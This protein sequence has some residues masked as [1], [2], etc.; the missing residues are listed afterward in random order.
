[1]QP[2][3]LQTPPLTLFFLRVADI[4]VSAAGR[5][6]VAG[7]WTGG[8]G[9]QPSS[10][11]SLPGGAVCWRARRWSWRTKAAGPMELLGNQHLQHRSQPSVSCVFHTIPILPDTHPP[12]LSMCSRSARRRWASSGSMARATA[13]VCESRSRKWKLAN[14]PSTSAAFAARC[15]RAFA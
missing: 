1:M 10:P 9:D 4:M 11:A 5:V 8:D 7:R 6:G 13:R 14:T 2:I 3:P 12:T 15:V